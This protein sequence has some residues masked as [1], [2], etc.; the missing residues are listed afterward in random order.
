MSLDSYIVIITTQQ[1]YSLYKMSQLNIFTANVMLCKNLCKK[2][3]KYICY[4]DSIVVAK[5]YYHVSK[6][7][8]TFYGCIKSSSETTQR[9]TT[10]SPFT[11]HTFTQRVAVT[12]EVFAVVAGN[13]FIWLYVTKYLHACSVTAGRYKLQIHQVL[14]QAKIFRAMTR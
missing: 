5:H 14:C 4:F 9:V 1:I 7:N 10:C 11:R 13:F 12:K 3:E 2:T 6:V 8:Y